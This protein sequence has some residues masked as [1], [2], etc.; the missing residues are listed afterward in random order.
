MMCK[1]CGSEAEL[2]HIDENYIAYGMCGKCQGAGHCKLMIDPIFNNL[3]VGTQMN[4]LDCCSAREFIHMN[5]WT[6]GRS[7]KRTASLQTK[8]STANL[9]CQ[10]LVS[11][12]MTILRGFGE[13]LE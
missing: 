13:R 8:H 2:T 7:S 5:T 12:T 3:R 6:A 10:K 1:E 9:T 4:S 11:V